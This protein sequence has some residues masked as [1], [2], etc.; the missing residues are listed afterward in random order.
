MFVSKQK[1]KLAFNS[2]STYNL[3]IMELMSSLLKCC[4]TLCYIYIF[5]SRLLDSVHGGS[6]RKHEGNQ[7]IT[8]LDQ[9]DQLFAKAIKF[10]VEESN[11][12]TE[13]V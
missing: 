7:G 5:S 1:L 13:K 8:P 2:V 9:Q 11:A 10:P 12:W 3:V 6:S 4:G